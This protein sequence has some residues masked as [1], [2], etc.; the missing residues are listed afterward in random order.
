MLACCRQVVGL[1]PQAS[2]LVSLMMRGCKPRGNCIVSTFLCPDYVIRR[3]VY[4]SDC[5]LLKGLTL[6]RYP[7]PRVHPGSPIAGLR[8]G[9]DSD[10]EI[11]HILSISESGIN[12]NFTSYYYLKVLNV[13][14]HC[15]HMIL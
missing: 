3:P 7:V 10:M 11:H 4:K 5:L 14:Q 2:D 13:A 12:A 8:P 1:I 9:M 6:Q 15:D